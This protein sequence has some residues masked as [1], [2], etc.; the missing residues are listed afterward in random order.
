MKYIVDK[1]RLGKSVDESSTRLCRTVQEAVD[2]ANPG[3][4]I[5]IEAGLYEEKVEI[6][7]SGLTIEGTSSDDTIIRWHDYARK[8]HDDGTDYGTFRSYSLL[9]LADDVTVRHLTI[10]NTA[11]DGRK[12]GQAIAL[13]ADGERLV[14]DD[15]RLIA[16]QDT[17]Y[18]GPLPPSPNIPGSFKG[19]TEKMIYRRSSQYYKDCYIIGDVDFI[20]GSALVL[21]EGCRMVSRD[22]GESINGFVTAPSTWEGEPYGYVF[23]G[24]TFEGEEGI[25]KDSVFFGRP[26]RPYGQVM[27]VDCS[28]DA[29]IRHDHWDP[30]GKEENKQTARFSEYGCKDA[31]GQISLEQNDIV[32]YIKQQA[33][34]PDMS[35]LS[36]WHKELVGLSQC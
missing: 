23:L 28:Y 31:K 14:F 11:G 7:T 34:L 36:S 4:H 8:I 19:P 15:C 33:N 12:V 24:C 20:F 35:F 32:P 26:W 17:L 1:K 29:C 21:F 5:L 9:V 6:R 16:Y 18:T 22:R 25:A 27:L 30:W 13:F 10:E 2:L 3:D